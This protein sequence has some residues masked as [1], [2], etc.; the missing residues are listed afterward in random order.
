MPWLELSFRTDTK[1]AE[2]LADAL[3]EAGAVSATFQDAGNQA[4]FELAPGQTP[5]WQQVEVTALF[6]DD[7][8]LDTV[9]KEVVRITGISPLPEMTSR[10]VEDQDWQRAWMDRFQP[11]C[12]GTRL[13]ICPSWQTPPQPDAVNVMIDPGLAFGTGTHPTTAMCLRWLDGHDLADKTVIDYGCG[14]GLLAIAALRLG[15]SHAWGVD[16]D[17]QAVVVSAENAEINGVADQL[18]LSTT[19]QPDPPAAD[20]MVANILAGPLQ[21]LAPKLA[22]LTRPGGQIVLSGI[23][24]EQ[25]SAVSA[26]YAPWF[27]MAPP[28]QTEEWVMLEGRKK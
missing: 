13:W 6:T 2:I 17:P 21:E 7:A 22:A 8:D 11:L 9:L 4:L 14:S 28:L 19:E 20:I 23:L 3:S 27:D 15:A 5:L 18:T 12:M 16:N 24:A 26:A 1:Q 25:A 10:Q